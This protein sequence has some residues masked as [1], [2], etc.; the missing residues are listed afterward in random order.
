MKQEPIGKICLG[1][2]SSMTDEQLT[3]K[4]MYDD[5]LISCC[6]DRKMVDVYTAPKQLSDEEIK[7]IFADQTG[8]F[9]DCGIV[10]GLAIMDFARAILK[11]ANNKQ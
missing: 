10:R 5:K 11:K 1:C 2:G 4:K 9:I 7:Q 6:P 3:L 8:F